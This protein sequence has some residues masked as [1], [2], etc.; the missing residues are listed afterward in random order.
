V[1][2]QVRFGDGLEGHLFLPSGGG[3]AGA[4]VILHERYGLV[5]HTLDLAQKLADDGYVALAPDLFS[6]W[7]GDKEALKRGDVHA[8]LADEEIGFVVNGGL[9]FLKAHAR[10]DGGKLAVM[11]VCQSGR[12][13]I[14]I[15]CERHDL[16]GLVIFYGG[17]QDSDWE[18]TEYQPK[19]M[20]AMIAATNAPYLCVFGES[21]H[22]V[23]VDDMLRLKSTL[24]QARKSYRMRL[25]P[26]MP[27]GWLNDTMPGRYRPAEAKDA[28]QLLLK[29]LGDTFNKSWPGPGR[30]AWEFSSD[31]AED[32]D[33]GKNVRLE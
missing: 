3:K 19:P 31:I 1:S 22:V 14:T 25:Y 24:E 5:Q 2:E 8:K 7:E 30:V 26:N 32:Y 16:S 20:P 10:V 9:D 13:P 33:F 21:D 15:G 6:R 18:V 4:V 17:A 12:Y 11:G 27:H 23:S 28:W 29:F